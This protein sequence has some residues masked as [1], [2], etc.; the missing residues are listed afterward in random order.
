MTTGKSFV[1][2]FSYF[3]LVGSS[4]EKNAGLDPDTPNEGKSIIFKYLFYFLK[5]AIKNS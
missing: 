1:S 2:R 4:P 5:V 3:K